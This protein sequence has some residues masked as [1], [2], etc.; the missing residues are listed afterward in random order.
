M[1]LRQKQLIQ[2]KIFVQKKKIN[3]GCTKSAKILIENGANVNMKA[4][5]GYYP[6]HAAAQVLILFLYKIKRIK[7]SRR[8][9]GVCDE[10]LENW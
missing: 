4:M 1:Y 5:H 7:T 8:N 3:R 6:L 9:F 10:N 2:I